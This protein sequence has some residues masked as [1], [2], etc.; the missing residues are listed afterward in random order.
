MNLRIEIGKPKTDG[1][2]KAYILIGSC[3]DKQRIPTNVMLHQGEF[4]KTPAGLKI[5]NF[6]KVLL[7]TLKQT[8]YSP[9][10]TVDLADLL[11]RHFFLIH[12]IRNK[13]YGVLTVIG[14]S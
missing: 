7:Q 14:T 10:P 5:L 8:F 6:E 12:Y 4:K 11:C 1:T 13:L 9:A 3:Q 2:C